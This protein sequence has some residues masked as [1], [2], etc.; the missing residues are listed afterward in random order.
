MNEKKTKG[1]LS[2]KYRKPQIVDQQTSNMIDSI[3]LK[4]NVWGLFKLIVD[5]S[6]E[7][8]KV[9]SNF[10]ICS[11]CMKFFAYNGETTST[12]LRHSACGKGQPSMNKFVVKKKATE[13]KEMDI[14]NVRE[15]AMKFVVK[16]YRPF[17]AI[18]CEGLKDLCYAMVLFG[19]KYSNMSKD[20][21]EKILPSRQTVGRDVS[22]RSL[23]LINVMSKEMRHCLN[24]AGGFAATTDLWTDNYKRKSYMSITVH[25]NIFKDE[26]ITPKVYIINMDTIDDEIKDGEAILR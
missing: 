5:E 6:T 15:A 17:Y 2:Y 1:Q 23:E 10:V 13:F 18:E 20:D 9:I 21:F 22:A 11:S 8:K 12:L 4:S 14:K 7:E 24:F 3:R 26:K 19:Q 16:D 25:L